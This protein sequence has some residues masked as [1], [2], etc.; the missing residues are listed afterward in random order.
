MQEKKNTKR[1][2][3]M[4]TG[5][6]PNKLWGYD[7]EQK[8]Y[9]LLKNRIEDE[10]VKIT[11]DKPFRMISGMALG[12]DML[13]ALL[14]LDLKDMYNVELFC[15]VPCKGQAT[16]WNFYDKRIYYSTLKKADNVYYVNDCKYFDGCMQERNQFMVDLCDYAIAVWDGSSG[17]TSD[18]VNRIKKANKPLIIINPFQRQRSL[19]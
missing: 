4:I 14:A 8:P 16:N 15:T 13:Y 3:I 10:L 11:D 1:I 5:H 12:V 19:F 17:G 2:N 6:R 18:T 9:F 7:L